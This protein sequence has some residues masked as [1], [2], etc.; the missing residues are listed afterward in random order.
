[1]ELAN[2]LEIDQIKINLQ[3]NLHIHFKDALKAKNLSFLD[4]RIHHNQLASNLKDIASDV[5]D[6]NRVLGAVGIAHFVLSLKFKKE[7]YCKK[8]SL[9]EEFKQKYHNITRQSDKTVESIQ[10]ALER[11]IDS[12]LSNVDKYSN[13]K[14]AQLTQTYED[15]SIR[16]SIILKHSKELHKD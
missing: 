3:D 7:F 13:M 6:Y 10:E 4:S 1:M 8:A 15:V 11:R 14:I 2:R 9:Q 16:S 12:V 5:S